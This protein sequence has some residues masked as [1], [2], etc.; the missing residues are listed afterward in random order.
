[1]IKKFYKINKKKYKNED[2]LTAKV[3]S[4][5]STNKYYNQALDAG[6]NV[7]IVENN[8]IVQVDKTRNKKIIS[9]LEHPDYKLS[10]I[11]NI[12]KNKKIKVILK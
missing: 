3:L 6:L 8:N 5:L 4:S 10:E 1:M 12:L 2:K 7:L 9:K 11:K